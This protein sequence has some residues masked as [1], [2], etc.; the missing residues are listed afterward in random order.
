M[1]E[2]DGRWNSIHMDRDS[3]GIIAL[4]GG[5]RPLPGLLSD[6]V[7]TS[8]LSGLSRRPWPSRR[9]APSNK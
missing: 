5:E 6:S 1:I 7:S 4:P 9:Q 3:K 2:I 8:P